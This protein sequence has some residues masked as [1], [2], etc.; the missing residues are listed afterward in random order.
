MLGVIRY[1]EDRHLAAGRVGWN[2]SRGIIYEFRYRSVWRAVEH[3]GW[4][5]VAKNECHSLENCYYCSLPFRA[6]LGHCRESEHRRLD[7]GMVRQESRDARYPTRHFAALRQRILQLLDVGLL[8]QDVRHILYSH[9]KPLSIFFLDA[10]MS[11]FEVK[12][13]DTHL[14]CLHIILP[15]D[16]LYRHF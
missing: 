15:V 13:P 11:A 10:A 2:S 1:V 4:G 12:I 14:I 6:I 7:G 5:L 3:C 16:R 9:N 8:S